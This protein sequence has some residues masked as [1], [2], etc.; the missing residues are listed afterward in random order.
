MS[1]SKISGRIKN[2]LTTPK[3]EWPKIADEP[4]T[5][6]GLYWSYI[7]IIAAIPLIA[8]LINLNLTGHKTPGGPNIILGLFFT[9]PLYVLSLVSIYAVALIINMLAP[10]FGGQRSLNQA[11]KAAAY[12]GTASCI[13]GIGKVVSWDV[14][15]MSIL[16]GSIYG[17]YLLHLGLSATMRCPPEKAGA[18]TAASVGCAIVCALVFYP[19]LAFVW[20][21]SILWFGSGHG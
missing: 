13:G 9:I 5:V 1:I 8:G 10:A 19:I 3:T 20:V 17:I 15:T 11:L 2:I 6:F 7:A 14:G 18:Y 12:A 16:A 21:T 4:V